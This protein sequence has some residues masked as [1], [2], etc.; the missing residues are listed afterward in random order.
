MRG[1]NGDVH[2]QPVGLAVCT[3]WYSMPRCSTGRSRQEDR[4]FFE[5]MRRPRLRLEYIA[6]PR[7]PGTCGD[8][9]YP[10]AKSRDGA[11]FLRAPQ[12]S[13]ARLL[14]WGSDGGSP[15]TIQN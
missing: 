7:G 11:L 1:F 6:R 4:K 12:G 2:R 8:A 10:E 14:P 15:T 3:T 9:H 5:M 13:F